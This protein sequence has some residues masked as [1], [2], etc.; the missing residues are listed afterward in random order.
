MPRTPIRV[1]LIEDNAGDTRLI[2]E[3]L[4]EATDTPVRLACVERLSDGLERLAAGGIDLLLLDL[5]LPDGQGLEVCAR[6]HAEARH[7]PIVVLTGLDDEVMAARALQIGAE[8]YLIKGEINSRLL[9]RSMRYAIDRR[10]ANET[11]RESELKFRSLAEQSPNM[12]FI[13]RRDRLAYANAVCADVTGYSIDELCADDFDFFQLIAP[14]SRQMVRV[15]LRKRVKGED[16]PPCECRLLARD[17]R[18]IETQIATKVIDYEGEDALLGIVTDLTE[19]TKTQ[20]QLRHSQLLASLGEM[21]A[22][23]VHEVN[24]PLASVLLY[25]EMLMTDD[26]SQQV[27]KDLKVIHDEARRAATIMS[28]LLA[29]SRRTELQV[30]RLNLHQLLKK[31]RD[32]RRY[33]QR[34]Q[35]IT[36]VTDFVEGPLYVRGDS[37]QLTQVFMNLILNAEEALKG[38]GGGNITIT[39]RRNGEWAVVS[40]ADDAVGIPQENLNQ[41]FYPFFS[42]KEVGE[43]T[44]LG[45]S[46]CYGIVTGH[47]GLIRAENNDM[48]GATFT[49]ELPL[50]RSR[51]RSDQVSPARPLLVEEGSTP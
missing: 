30:R 26:V 35:N 17:A 2:R 42:T 50:A 47:K 22:G 14:E 24:N 29:Y 3:M 45:L 46:T 37:S 41:V 44:G 31:V 8:D 11:L 43:G 15:N 20:G 28:D 38:T 39:T 18:Q 27:R 21:T 51:R 49:V 12:I 34:V 33:P 48:G 6:A 32:M 40:I 36:V 19:L 4:S 10:Q 25:S 13:T 23:I 5:S 7:V 16:I 9:M 1:L